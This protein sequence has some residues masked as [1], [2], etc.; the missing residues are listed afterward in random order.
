MVCILITYRLIFEV[1]I[2]YSDEERGEGA[3]T[4]QPAQHVGPPGELVSVVLG[5]RDVG[6]CVN[7]NRLA[8]AEAGRGRDKVGEKTQLIRY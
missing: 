5:G 7:K 2:D 3:G 4:H 8:G 6:Q 1:P